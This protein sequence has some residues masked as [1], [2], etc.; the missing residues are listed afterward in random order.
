MADQKESLLQVRLQTLYGLRE[1][2][3]RREL[4]VSEIVYGSTE[5]LKVSAPNDVW[6]QSLVEDDVV[7]VLPS[8]LIKSPLVAKQLKEVALFQPH[9]IRVPI[10]QVLNISIKRYLCGRVVLFDAYPLIKDPGD[11]IQ[12]QL[13]QV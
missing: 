6:P 4:G 7:L 2:H 12:I 10:D 8:K 3:C 13:H 11:R 5:R 9:Q 1:D